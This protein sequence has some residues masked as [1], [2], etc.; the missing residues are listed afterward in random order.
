MKYKVGDKIRVKSL[1]V[2]LK[3]PD[4]EVVENCIHNLYISNFYFSNEMQK[5]CNK[6][7]TITSIDIVKR[8]YYSNK[9]EIILFSCS[10]IPSEKGEN[11]VV[12]YTKEFGSGIGFV[13]WMLED[14]LQEMIKLID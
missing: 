10:L 3:V 1:N 6:K 7:I 4:I 13:D 5:F 14:S 9:E 11:I 2:L 12:Y 8:K